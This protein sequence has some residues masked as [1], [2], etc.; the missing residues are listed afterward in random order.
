MAKPQKTTEQQ[1]G[2]PGEAAPPGESLGE[3]LLREAREGQAEFVV[4]WEEFMEE[5]GIQGQP[6]S[7]RELREKL[8]R[9]GIKPENNEF[10]RGIVA[11]REE[12]M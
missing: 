11:M 9:E 12:K 5:R 4:G 10:S 6:I 8:L 3:Q 7:A 2:D 1:Q